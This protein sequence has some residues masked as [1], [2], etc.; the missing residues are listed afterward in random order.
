M[1]VWRFALTGLA[2]AAA[3]ALCASQAFAVGETAT[4]TIKLANGTDAGTVTFTEGTAGVL[5]KFELKGLTPGAHAVH[6]YET[7][8]CEGDFSSAGGIYNPL[9]AKHG[10]LH[11]EGP[12]AGDLPNIHAGVDGAV[13]AEILSPFLTLS[14]EAEES[15]FDGDGAAIIIQEKADDYEAD[16]DGG[17]G[18]RV[19]CGVISIKK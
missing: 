4:A 18:A 12:M 3:L 6:V 13:T 10:F 5:L 16:P 2:S 7:G 11:D 14:T 1:I 19:G 8:K 15:L 9:G 17:A